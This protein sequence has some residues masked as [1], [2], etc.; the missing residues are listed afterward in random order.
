MKVIV[1]F[2]STGDGVGCRV[3]KLDNGKWHGKRNEKML[4]KMASLMKEL[5]GNRLTD[6]PFST[7]WSFWIE[8]HRVD[9]PIGEG[10]GYCDF[11]F[12]QKKNCGAAASYV[13]RKT[14]EIIIK[15]LRVDDDL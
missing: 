12:N 1:E 9:G 7:E 10:K 8:P 3:R 4:E 14:Y 5:V 11:N 15:A 13:G 6:E 2:G